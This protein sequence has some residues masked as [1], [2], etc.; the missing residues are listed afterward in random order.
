MVDANTHGPIDTLVI[1]YPLESDG[2]GTAAALEDLVARGTVNLYDL[3]V[4]TKDASGNCSE[5]DLA[6]AT[7]G[8]LSGLRK[9]AG[10]RSGLLGADDVDDLGAVIEPKTAAVVVVYENAWAVPFVAAAR[11]EGAEVVAGARLS[12]QEIMD[13]IDAADAAN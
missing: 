1:E 9:F 10:A 3:M 8:P 4:V 11:G 7:E 6:A 13:A 12:A 2:S 5:V